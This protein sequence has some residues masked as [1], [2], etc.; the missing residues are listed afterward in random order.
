MDVLVIGDVPIADRAGLAVA[1]QRVTHT[2]HDH[3]DRYR[4]TSLHVHGEAVD[5]RRDCE[6]RHVLADATF[7]VR[8]AAWHLLRVPG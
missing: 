4:G 2:G 6:L 8:P 7:T 5:H 1:L 3:V